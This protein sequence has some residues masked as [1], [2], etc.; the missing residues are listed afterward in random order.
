MTAAETA[1]FIVK[2]MFFI[3]MGVFLWIELLTG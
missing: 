2:Y 3:V 1:H